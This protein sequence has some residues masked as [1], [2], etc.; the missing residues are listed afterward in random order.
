MFSEQTLDVFLVSPCLRRIILRDLIIE[1]ILDE[2]HMVKNRQCC[3]TQNQSVRNTTRHCCATQSVRNT[4]P[5]TSVPHTINP[6]KYKTRHCCATHN[7]SVR[8]KLRHCCAT[9]PIC[10]NTKPATAVLHTTN[11]SQH[12]TRHC[13][14]RHNQ[15]VRTQ[16]PPLPCYTQPIRQITKP[17]TAVPHRTNLPSICHGQPA[18]RLLCFRFESRSLAVSLRLCVMMAGM[19]LP[20]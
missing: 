14:A 12:K 20:T 17:A 18:S 13:C 5:A 9:Q 10:Q 16:N 4:K 19:Q 7:Q 15:S 1:I 11:L 6:S 3:P 2:G 8:T